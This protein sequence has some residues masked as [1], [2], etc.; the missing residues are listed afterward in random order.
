MT[1]DKAKTQKG[2]LA[3]PE[4]CAL[5][6]QSL[7]LGTT[8]LMLEA[9]ERH[10]EQLVDWQ[11]KEMWP[12]LARSFENFIALFELYKIDTD[13]EDKWF[14]L[15]FHLAQTYVPS[16]KV[17]FSTEKRGRKPSWTPKQHA[18]LYKAVTEMQ[19]RKA[20]SISAICDTLAM[21]PPW[22][23]LVKTKTNKDKDTKSKTLENQYQLSKQSLYVKLYTEKFLKILP[24]DKAK[25]IF[26]LLCADESNPTIKSP[27]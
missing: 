13:D 4:K 27:V 20:R 23:D 16:C 6:P 1:K 19:E 21:Q 8:L 12:A 17:D 14:W 24:A 15:A 11:K 3:P 18:Q 26:D 25:E 7:G 2:A 9:L 22:K 5:P 10:A